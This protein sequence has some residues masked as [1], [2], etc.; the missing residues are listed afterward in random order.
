VL[1][2]LERRRLLAAAVSVVAGK[3]T[4][5]GTAIADTVDISKTTGRTARHRRWRPKKITSAVSSI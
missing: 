3:L 5:A 4:I 1:E 2:G